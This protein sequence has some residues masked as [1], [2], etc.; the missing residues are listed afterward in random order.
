MELAAR[1]LS[2][3]VVVVRREAEGWVYLLLRVYNYWDFAKGEVQPG[4][5]PL[6][7]ARREVAEEAGLKDLSFF[8]GHV[9]RETAPYGR[10]KIARYYVAQTRE[11]DIELPISEELGRPEHHEARW[12]SYPEAR[13]L[14]LP[15]LVS[16]LDWANVLI[17][18]LKDSASWGGTFPVE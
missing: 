5:D 1:V 8:W 12:V 15:R 4:E 6:Q 9:Y 7:T 2:A 3:G 10:G 16:I 13:S 11:K 14:L 17:T 18:G